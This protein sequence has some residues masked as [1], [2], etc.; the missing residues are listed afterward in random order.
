MQAAR[1]RSRRLE[2]TPSVLASP[3]CGGRGR[4]ACGSAP[5]ATVWLACWSPTMPSRPAITSTHRPLLVIHRTDCTPLLWDGLGEKHGLKPLIVPLIRL[6]KFD[7]RGL[8]LSLSYLE[9]G[10]ARG[11]DGSQ[12]PQQQGLKSNHRGEEHGR[13]PI[14]RPAEVCHT[15]KLGSPGCTESRQKTPAWEKCQLNVCSA[16][17]SR[18]NH[19]PIPESSESK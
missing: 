13:T 1:R 11:S 6:A 17:P 2:E 15:L 7:P 5:Q 18:T 19:W 3:A 4:G 16:P 9:L 10:W 14:N 12:I 8:S